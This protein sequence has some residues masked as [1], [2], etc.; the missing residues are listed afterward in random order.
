MS[1]ERLDFGPVPPMVYVAMFGATVAGQL[2]GMAIDAVAIG[3]RVLWFPLALSV[4][5]EALVGARF[6]ASLLGRPLT[7]SESGR[8][9]I[10]YSAGLA[11]LSLP[12]AAW[13]AVSTGMAKP[14]QDGSLWSLRAAG[15]ALTLAVGVFAGGAVLRQLLML[16]VAR[17]RR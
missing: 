7:S 1:D 6:G 13:T 14:A 16:L 9:S 8:V 2:G 10:Y 17:A 11:A 4:V 12:L 3:R 5:L 15:V